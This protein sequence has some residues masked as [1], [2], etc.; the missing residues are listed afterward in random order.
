[1]TRGYDFQTCPF[2]RGSVSASVPRAPVHWRAR[3]GAAIVRAGRRACA[4]VSAIVALARAFDVTV[5]GEGVET[6]EQLDALA[7]TGCDI[8]WRIKSPRLS[9]VSR[10]AKNR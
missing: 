2:G 10:D 7:A 4:I 9:G 8:A 1:M 6:E 3:A 5:V